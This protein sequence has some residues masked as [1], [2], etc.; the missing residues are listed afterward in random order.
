MLLQL[1]GASLLSP[2]V[3]DEQLKAFRE[4]AIKF[5]KG[6]QTHFQSSVQRVKQD[7]ALVPLA[8]ARPFDDFTHTVLSLDTD[9]EEFAVAVAE[10]KSSFSQLHPWISWWLRK[11]IALLIF[12]ACCLMDEQLTAQLPNT[13]NPIETQHS[14]L[15]HASKSDHEP[16][17]GLREIYR[18][19]EELR[20][21]HQAIL[22]VL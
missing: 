14:L 12:P 6:C 8:Y 17:A 5:Q 7:S 3:Q 1:P 22:G 2:A 19:V 16:L 9:F 21:R 13:S 20:Q 11:K 4:M 15:H 18:H 10:F